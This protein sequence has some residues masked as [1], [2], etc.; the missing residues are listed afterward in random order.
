[1][2]IGRIAGTLVARQKTRTGNSLR[3]N[4]QVIKKLSIAFTICVATMLGFACQ[5]TAE[6]TTN[7]NVSA[8]SDAGQ[9]AAA[10]TT[11]SAPDNSE[12]TTTTDASGVR[13]ETR[14]FR[15]NPKLSK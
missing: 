10:T 8:N 4:E 12:I 9:T 14:V 2:L 15:D 5:S 7:M 6:S 11:R 13:T 3:R 1:M